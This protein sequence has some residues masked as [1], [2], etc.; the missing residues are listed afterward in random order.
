MLYFFFVAADHYETIVWSQYFFWIVKN[1]LNYIQ[2][3][4]K[5]HYNDT[6]IRDYLII[7]DYLSIIIDK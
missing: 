6:C 1:S 3:I 7:T 2:N 4:Q 5:L